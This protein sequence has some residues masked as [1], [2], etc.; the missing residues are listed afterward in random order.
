MREL[1]LEKEDQDD[2]ML[3]EAKY[4]FQNNFVPFDPDKVFRCRLRRPIFCAECEGAVP[5]TLEE[6]N[7]RIEEKRLFCHFKLPENTECYGIRL[8]KVKGDLILLLPMKDA[9]LPVAVCT[10]L[11]LEILGKK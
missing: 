1:K 2:G 8:E 10:E 7:T 11:D 9:V 4:V 6:I 5:A 3:E